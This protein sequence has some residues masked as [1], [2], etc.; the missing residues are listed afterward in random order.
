MNGFVNRCRRVTSAIPEKLP[1]WLTSPF[2]GLMPR[3]FG[4]VILLTSAPTILE[5]AAVGRFKKAAKERGPLRSRETKGHESGS[6][7]RV[8]F[9]NQFPVERN[10]A[11]W[12][13]F[14]HSEP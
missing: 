13:V 9:A 12:K 11:S 10:F 7:S 1:N 2:I 5:S 4:A 6:L 3:H 14:L 8:R